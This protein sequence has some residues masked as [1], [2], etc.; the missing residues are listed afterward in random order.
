MNKRDEMTE[1]QAGYQA[2][3][4]YPSISSSISVPLQQKIQSNICV[5]FDVPI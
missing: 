3:S 1:S 4:V 5:T 2:E